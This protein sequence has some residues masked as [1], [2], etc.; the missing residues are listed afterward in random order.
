MGSENVKRGGS[1]MAMPST[2]YG[3]ALPVIEGWGGGFKL[4][5]FDASCIFTY[6]TRHILSKYYFT[7]KITG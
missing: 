6:R 4:V 2:W 5:Q 3:S 1:S 7:Y